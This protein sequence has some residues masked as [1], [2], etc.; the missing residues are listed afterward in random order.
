MHNLKSVR[1]ANRVLKSM[2]DYL[3]SFRYGQE[4][5]YYLSKKGRDRVQSEKIRKKTPNVQHYLLRNQLFIAL[6]HPVTWE[7][8]MKLIVDRKTLLISDAKF[9]RKKITHFVEVD[10]AQAM[11]ENQR[12]IERYKRFKELT[13]E[14]FH[15][16]WI[17]EL[18][19]RKPRLQE[20]SVGLTGKV[21]TL[22]EVM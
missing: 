1:N 5:V 2:E 21:Y 20:L 16:L 7:N 19:S 17:T 15:L 6:R 9:E 13:G 4:K 18:E 12:K 10:C 14:K 3:C 11:Q 22:G 8:E